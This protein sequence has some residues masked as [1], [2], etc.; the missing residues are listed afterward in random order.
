MPYYPEWQKAYVQRNR[1]RIRE[2]ERERYAR[3]HPPKPKIPRTEAQV[4]ASKQRR[5]S[6]QME[7]R[8]ANLE[9]ARASERDARNRHRD[10]INAR[11]RAEY[12]RNREMHAANAKSRRQENPDLFLAYK[13]R[14][15]STE[16]GKLINRASAHRRRLGKIGSSATLEEIQAILAAKRCYLC[17]KRF[18][19]TN[20]ATIEHVTALAEGGSNDVSNLAAAHLSCNSRKWKNRLNPHTG[21]GILI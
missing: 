12:G 4:L 17:G 14:Y 3:L 2:R 8:N 10:E 9:S 5:L 20:P 15:Y 7:R 6:L 19:K 13:R 1:A 21:Q 11:R 16:R 18:T